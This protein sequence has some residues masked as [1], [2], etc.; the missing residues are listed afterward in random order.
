MQFWIS[1]RELHFT[2]AV[3]ALNL[4]SGCKIPTFFC[5]DL[6]DAKLSFWDTCSREGN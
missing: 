1:P 5:F 4:C 6:L 2:K 3:S